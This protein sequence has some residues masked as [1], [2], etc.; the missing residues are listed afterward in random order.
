MLNNLLD[1][2]DCGL[3]TGKGVLIFSIPPK[4]RN[5]SIIMTIFGCG[6]F[7]LF[8]ECAAVV[9]KHLAVY[10]LT[11]P[12]CNRQLINLR[13]LREKACVSLINLIAETLT[14]QACVDSITLLNMEARN[15]AG[16]LYSSH[17]P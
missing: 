2:C 14:T 13:C 5:I 9:M 3:F 12:P 10:S 1:A 15:K 6:A 16:T 17:L 7:V 8:Q 4:V 11:F